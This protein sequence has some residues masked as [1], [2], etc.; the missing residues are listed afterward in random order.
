MLLAS[1]NKNKLIEVK[2]GLMNAFEM[3]DLGGPKHF[4]NM[5]LRSKR[6]GSDDL[7]TQNTPMVTR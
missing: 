6:F 3:T 7:Y 1:N 5:K 2:T 4:M